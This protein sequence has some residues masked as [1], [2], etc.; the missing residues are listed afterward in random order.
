MPNDSIASRYKLDPRGLNLSDANLDCPEVSAV[1]PELVG[2]RL[3]DP[4]HRRVL[5]AAVSACRDRLLGQGIDLTAYDV[6]ANVADLEDF[7]RALDIPL[8]NINS[9]VNGSRVMETYVRTH[10]DVFRAFVMDSPALATPD[11]LTIGPAALDLAIERLSAACAAQPVCH[12]RMPDVSGAIREAT[13]K[14]DATPVTID[15]DGTLAAIQFG[16][17][18]RVVIDGAAYLRYVRHTVG[19]F[20]GALSSE[21][22]RTTEEVLAGTLGPDDSIATTL[23]SDPGDCLGL[24]PRCDRVNFGAL[25]SLVCGSLGPSI[26][27]GRLEADIAGRAAYADLF[28]PSPLLTACEVWPAGPAPVPPAPWPVDVPTLVLRGWFDPYSTPPDDIK[29][30]IGGPNTYIYDVPNQSYNALGEVDCPRL[31]RNAWIDAPG[32]PPADV[33]CLADIAPVI[34]AP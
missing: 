10:P 26:D 16:H 12:D 33:S 32:A 29:A 9:N 8:I 7:R 20:G 18:I 1:G 15:V 6:A 27:H 14:L 31:I 5:L 22:V 2:L 21:V 23:A 34:V 3:R 28:D 11:V 4:E 25:Y 30:A 19:G 13:E 24:L 17:P